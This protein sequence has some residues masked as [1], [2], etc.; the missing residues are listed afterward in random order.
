MH[1]SLTIMIIDDD[2]LTRES[3]QALLEAEGF[4]AVGARNGAEA[5]LWLESRTAAMILLDL[6]MPV[7]DGRSFLE[8][9]ARQ[10]K[11]RE[12]P[13]LVVSGWLDEAETRETLL[14]L[15]AD[16]L[17]WKPVDQEDLLGTVREILAK[18]SA[19]DA[20]PP[21]EAQKSRR[22][23]D[24]R[25]A[26]TLPIR[27]RTGSSL[28]ASGRLCDISAGGL[29]A[30]LPRCLSDEETITVSLDIKGHSLALTGFVQWTAENPTG[31]GC[32]HGI[33]FAERQEDSFPLYTYSFYRDHSES[34][35]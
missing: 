20:P 7:M 2:P 33:R 28:E 11:I 23:Q 21:Q 15:G 13:V 18:R 12:V 25:V 6:K 32:R 27:V 19:S 8:H 4:S 26:F 1:T 3:Y 29:G 5:I 17:L 30:Y 22:R 16:R 14:Q 10:A 24:S 9:R 35:N 34:P 31:I